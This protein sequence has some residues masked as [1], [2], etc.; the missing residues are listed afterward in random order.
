MKPFNLIKNDVAGFMSPGVD[1]AVI[2]WFGIWVFQSLHFSM[3]RG[4]RVGM[5]LLEYSTEH[6]ITPTQCG[7]RITNAHN[8][9]TRSLAALDSNLDS[10]DLWR[11][12]VKGDSVSIGVKNALDSCFGLVRPH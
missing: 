3:R 2:S 4:G 12:S 10:R 6:T 9:F 11:M 1:S 5:H 7:Q 8:H